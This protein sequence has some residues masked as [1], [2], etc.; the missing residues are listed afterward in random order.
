MS[1][2]DLSKQEDLPA[3]ASKGE[4]FIFLREYLLVFNGIL[5]IWQFD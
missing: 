4:I 1:L 3:N 2:S 5:K